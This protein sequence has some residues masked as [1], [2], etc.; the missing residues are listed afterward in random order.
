M[1]RGHSRHNTICWYF[2]FPSYHIFLSWGS[3]IQLT[4]SDIFIK[5]LESHRRSHSSQVS[6]FFQ[7][8]FHTEIGLVLIETPLTLCVCVPH[9]NPACQ[10]INFVGLNTRSCLSV[11]LSF[12]PI[13]FCHVVMLPLLG[14]PKHNGLHP[15]F[16][17]VAVCSF[18]SQV[19]HSD[20]GEDDYRHSGPM[21]N[22]MIPPQH[23]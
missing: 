7:H 5:P 15:S 6:P 12:S 19:N 10:T 4:Y 14:C 18:L 9:R 1:Q 23:L 2:I 22:S 20:L 16:F 21:S 13:I 17:P 11:S 8:L 3:E